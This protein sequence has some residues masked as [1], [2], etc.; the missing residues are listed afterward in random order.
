MFSQNT[1]P[2]TDL[3]TYAPG[4]V[5]EMVRQGGI[6]RIDQEQLQAL[7]REERKTNMRNEEKPTPLGIRGIH[8]P[9]NRMVLLSN[10]F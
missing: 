9:T 10:R 5:A 7:T 8:A 6:T 3:R 2:L 1:H 4:A